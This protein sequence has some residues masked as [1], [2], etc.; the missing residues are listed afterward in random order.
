MMNKRFIFCV[1]TNRQ[2]DTD[3]NYIKKVMDYLYQDDLT[4]SYKALYMENKYHY[5]DSSFQEKINDELKMSNG[6]AF[7]IFCIDLDKYHIDSTDHSFYEEVQKFCEVN[8]YKLVYFSRNVEEV[9]LGYT[10][11]RNKKVKLAAKFYRNG[12]ITKELLEKLDRDTKTIGTS[13]LYR[14]ITELDCDINKNNK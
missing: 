7:I 13:N 14:V 1:E 2:S 11:E 9:F 8:N 3:W 4:C 10:P 12:E 5:N 6:N